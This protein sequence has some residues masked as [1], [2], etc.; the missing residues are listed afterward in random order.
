MIYPRHGEHSEAIQRRKIYPWIASSVFAL[1][2]M[3]AFLLPAYAED[4]PKETISEEKAA[5]ADDAEQ[6][7]DKEDKDGEAEAAADDKTYHYAPDFCDFEVTFPEAPLK[8]K[9]CP[10]G[11]SVCYDL[12]SYT[13][14]YDM[15]TTV[16]ISVTCNP[17]SEE[18]FKRYDENVMRTALE[19]MVM[20]NG[21]EDYTINYEETEGTRQ[22]SVSGS[23]KIGR[24]DKIFTSQLWVGPHSVFTL[25]AELIGGEHPVADETFSNILKSIHVKEGK[26]LPKPG[27]ARARNN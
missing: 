11:G 23:G 18:N 20:R 9:R 3:T 14:V 1:L 16:D 6:A 4:A 12:L 17:S 10:E 15:H 13:M 26:A 19:G 7:Q 5:P 24:Q 21:V 22:A 27:P 25:Q 2:A 8:T